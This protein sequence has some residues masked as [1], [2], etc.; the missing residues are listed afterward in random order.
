MFLFNMFK[1]E[2]RGLLISQMEKSEQVIVVCHIDF[3]NTA[4]TE[5]TLK[6]VGFKRNIGSKKLVKKLLYTAQNHPNDIFSSGRQGNSSLR[7]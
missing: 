5:Q 2:A 3:K 7:V 1:S 4:F 6:N